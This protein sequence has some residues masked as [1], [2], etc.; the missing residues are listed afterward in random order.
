MGHTK[1]WWIAFLR[2]EGRKFERENPK[3]STIVLASA[4]QEVLPKQDEALYGSQINTV[5]N[6]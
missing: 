3:S 4:S 6:L 5:L 1:W 2:F